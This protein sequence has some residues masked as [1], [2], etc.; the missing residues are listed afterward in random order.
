MQ[1]H[2]GPR[3]H[4]RHI[5]GGQKGVRVRLPRLCEHESS[6]STTRHSTPRARRPPSP[7]VALSRTG[8]LRCRRPPV[9]AEKTSA[10]SFSAR[11]VLPRCALG[12]QLGPLKAVQNG[13]LVAHPSGHSILLC[14]LSKFQ[15]AARQ[16]GGEGGRAVCVDPRVAGGRRGS[17]EDGGQRVIPLCPGRPGA[18]RVCVFPSP[19]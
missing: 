5:H 15:N 14:L 12:G 17:D 7:A 3:H 19:N 9:T 10:G 18:V 16:Y 11:I 8:S 4:A 6:A 2:L 13:L 1:Q